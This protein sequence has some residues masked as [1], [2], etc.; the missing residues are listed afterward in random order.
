MEIKKTNGK[1]ASKKI[2]LHADV[3][4]ATSLNNSWFLTG[5]MKIEILSSAEGTPWEI[6]DLEEMCDVCL[7]NAMAVY[8][9]LLTWYAGP[10]CQ[11]DLDFD[12]VQEYFKHWGPKNCKLN[13][14]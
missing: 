2:H 12:S 9:A 7:N 10:Y 5:T 13:H 4:I 1:T 11:S 3:V 6:T 14:D 8:F